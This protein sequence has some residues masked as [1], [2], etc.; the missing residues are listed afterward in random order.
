M[1]I[2][3]NNKINFKG[4]ECCAESEVRK[5]FS[6]NDQFSLTFCQSIIHSDYCVYFAL[7]GF[8]CDF[9]CFNYFALT[10]LKSLE[11]II[12]LKIRIWKDKK[13]RLK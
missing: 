7:E 12:K 13:G 3:K 1:K 9:R 2:C 4:E 11:F 5:D 6:N 8:Y 10:Q